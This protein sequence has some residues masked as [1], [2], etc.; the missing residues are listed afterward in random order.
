MKINYKFTTILLLILLITSL[1]FNIIDNDRD[2]KKSAHN[3]DHAD[4]YNMTIMS[5]DDMSSMLDDKTG[6]DLEKEFIVG[7]IPHHQGA[8]NMAKRLLSDSGV[9][10]EMKSFA[11]NI[12]SAQEGEINMMREWLKK[13]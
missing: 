13:Y 6:K 7:M 11:E 1:A 3:M 5:M 8:V 4:E 12:I 9:S 10:K 2:Y